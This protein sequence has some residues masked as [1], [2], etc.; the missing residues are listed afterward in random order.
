MKDRQG[1]GRFS[2]RGLERCRGEWQLAATVQ[3]TPGNYIDNARLSKPFLF[4]EFL[5]PTLGRVVFD[6]L[7]SEEGARFFRETHLHRVIELCDDRPL[8][9]PPSYRWFSADAVRHFL[10]LGE[11]VTSSARSILACVL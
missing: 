5:Q 6:A 8:A 2:M 11:V 7:Q 4:A 3:F 1:A 10:H 9:L